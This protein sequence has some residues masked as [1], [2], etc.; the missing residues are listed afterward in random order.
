MPVRGRAGQRSGAAAAALRMEP[1]ALGRG[2]RPRDAGG[3]GECP[4]KGA[5][6][7]RGT[8]GRGASAPP[9]RRRRAGREEGGPARSGAVSAGRAR[10]GG[11]SAAFPLCPRTPSPRGASAPGAALR[12]RAGGRGDTR[13]AAARCAERCAELRAS[14]L[15]CGTGT[16]P[17]TRLCPL[18]PA[19]G[20]GSAA[21]CR[22]GPGSSVAVTQNGTSLKAAV[23]TFLGGRSEKT[24]RE[25]SSI[26]SKDTLGTE[27][28]ERAG[29]ALPNQARL[30][31]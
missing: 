31:E 7:A 14:P 10:G 11:S 9:R 24:C 21:Q 25:A 18:R 19:P 1:A 23:V 16:A 26:K 20:C 5:W 13:L 8:G 17:G 3:G 4:R 30:R 22:T 12:S 29:R 15:T 6:A 27:V 28:P 2:G